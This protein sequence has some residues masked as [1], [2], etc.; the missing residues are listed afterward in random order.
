[1]SSRAVLFSAPLIPEGVTGLRQS[2]T[3][4][5]RSGPDSAGV[6]PDSAGV[7]QKLGLLLG[8]LIYIYLYS[9]LIHSK[10]NIMNIIIYLIH[11]ILHY[12][13]ALLTKGEGVGLLE[14]GMLF[15]FYI[16]NWG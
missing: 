8:G 15:I 13:R 6:A 11:S 9:Y 2:G 16:Y 10:F 5:R 7:G 14:M 1:M 12:S 3:G 4:L